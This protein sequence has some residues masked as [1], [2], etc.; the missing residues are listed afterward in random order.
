MSVVPASL[1]ENGRSLGSVDAIAAAIIG[2]F[3]GLAILGAAADAWL[4]RR[5]S[6]NKPQQQEGG[7]Q[8]RPR[9]WAVFVCTASYGLLIKGLT[10]TL[11]QYSVTILAMQVIARTENTI[12]LVQGLA[13]RGMGLA[14]A[15]IVTYA[16]V[17]PG[18][19]V[20]LLIL[21]QVLQHGGAPWQLR[22]AR[23]CILTVQVVSKW[24]SPDMFAYIL[25]LCLFRGL[26]NPPMLISQVQFGL[27]FSCYA[28]FCVGSTISSLGFPVPDL[29]SEAREVTRQERE[30]QPQVEMSR[31]MGWP[32]LPLVAALVA[33]FIV[34]LAVGMTLPVMELRLDMALLY[35]EKPQLKP[36]EGYISTLHLPEL[37]HE[38]VSG[39]TCLHTLVADISKGSINSCLAF[40][41]YGVFTMLLPL[42]DV[43]ALLIAACLMRISG[44]H[45]GLGG[46]DPALTAARVLGKL[47]MLD[48][49]IVGI[50]VIVLSMRE[51][52][53]SGVIVSMREGV[54]V[55][56]AAVICRYAASFIV[57]RAHASSKCS[58]RASEGAADQRS[59][60]N[61]EP[62][63][64][65]IV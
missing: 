13:A 4:S 42:M 23:R 62:E 37:M 35:E 19:K 9:L 17:I 47:S 6:E 16:M 25:L 28:V 7:Q 27:G 50:V 55:L 41:M 8:L 63:I 11:F 65:V 34:F 31:R 1:S 40:M 20:V 54:P 26:D 10:L 44:S 21:G 24:A 56:L 45:A 49:S 3:V 32:T 51:M 52:R 61:Q 60:V 64:T 30:S 5:R 14:A 58:E 48:V 53:Q 29:R 59:N 18:I 2:G 39:W 33:S 46:S 38:E 15:F 22:W 43:I 36:L 12:E 57:N